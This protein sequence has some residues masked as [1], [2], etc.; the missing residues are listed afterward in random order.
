MWSME[1]LLPLAA[2]GAAAGFLA[3]LL[4]I[5]GGAVTVPIVLWSLGRQGIAGEPAFGGGHVDGG[6]GVHYVF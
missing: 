3:G 2:V 5:G 6:D 1:V 4:G